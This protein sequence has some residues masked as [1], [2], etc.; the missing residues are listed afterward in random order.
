[1][2]A[3]CPKRRLNRNH[4]R[5]GRR[6]MKAI[7]PTDTE[8]TRATALASL[9]TVTRDRRLTQLQGSIDATLADPDD[10]AARRRAGRLAGPGRGSNF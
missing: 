1:M 2:S 10:D 9:R 3:K 8:R 6:T 7:P 4:P 5:H